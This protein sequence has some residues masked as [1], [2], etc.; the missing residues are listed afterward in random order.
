M[1]ARARSLLRGADELEAA[2]EELEPKPLI[3]EGFVDFACEVRD[4]SAILPAPTSS[5]HRVGV[6]DRR[7]K[8]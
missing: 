7:A 4:E 5:H 6:A 2:Y 8:R 1:T 3:L